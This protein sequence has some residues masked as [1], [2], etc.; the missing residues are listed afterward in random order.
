MKYSLA[1]RIRYAIATL[2]FLCCS[3]FVW[4][5]EN[6]PQ[7]TDFLELAA[8]ML[9]DGHNDRALLALQSVDLDNKK[10]DLARFYTLQGLAYMGLNDLEAAKDSLQQAI[11]N[12]QKDQALYLYL[13]QTHFGLKDY[14]Q[15]IDAINKAGNL[16]NKD[17]ALITLKAESYWHLKNTEAAINALND[18]QNIFPADFRFI[19][20]KV[21]YF[22]ELGLYQEAV[23]L[24]REVLHRSKAVA[25][26][27]IA[28]GNA[29]RLS[30]EYQ[31]ALNILEIARLQF[32]HDEMVAKLLAH[33]YLDQGKLNSAAFILEQAA[34]LNP[35]LQAEAAEIYRRA[36]RF[37][38]ALTLNESISDQKVKLKQRLSILLALKQFERAANMESSLYR[39]GLLEDQ[40][41]R[42]ALAYALFSSRRFSAAN[43][44]LD[45]LTSAELFRKGT[46]LRR[47]MEVCKN[48]PWQCT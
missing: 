36:G 40:D 33:T 22:V 13:A 18:G 47:L 35:N 28:L 46:E 41:V 38:K 26:D 2:I 23:R 32:P 3:N 4:S 21:F 19:K 42:Y 20:R 30:K 7:S 6:K 10:I 8:V 31:E 29:L 16:V 14:K 11:K 9:K 15:A 44:H 43:Q 39:T 1:K 34:L 17:A 48:E 45:H 25:A 24:G 27:Y 12:G 5:S 37:H